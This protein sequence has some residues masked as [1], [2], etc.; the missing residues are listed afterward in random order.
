MS[1]FPKHIMIVIARP[2]TAAIH[3]G[4]PAL[5]AWIAALRSQ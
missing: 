5:C 4:K 1:T 3:S 2:Q